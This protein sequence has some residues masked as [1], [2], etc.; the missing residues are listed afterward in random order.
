MNLSI[1]PINNFKAKLQVSNKK[2]T[3]YFFKKYKAICNVER[4]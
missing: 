2:L 1:T 4:S 3:L